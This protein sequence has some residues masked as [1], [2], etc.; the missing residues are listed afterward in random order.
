MQDKILFQ[1]KANFDP[2]LNQTKNNFWSKDY[3]ESIYGKN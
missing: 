3:L 2:N 1:S